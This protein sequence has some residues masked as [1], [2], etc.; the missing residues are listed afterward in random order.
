MNSCGLCG[1]ESDTPL[2]EWLAR[3][4][5]LCGEC[6]ELVTGLAVYQSEEEFKGLKS[7]PMFQRFVEK[8]LGGL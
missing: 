4:N 3:W 8:V 5:C 7:H 1:R 2:W 6:L